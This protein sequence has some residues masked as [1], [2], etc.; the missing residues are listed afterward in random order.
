MTTPSSPPPRWRLRG[1]DGFT[2]LAAIAVASICLLLASAVVAM[3][4]G[5]NRA[6]GVDRNR[7]QA[8]AAAEGGIDTALSVL[9]QLDPGSQAGLLTSGCQQTL[10]AAPTAAGTTVTLKYAFYLTASGGSPVACPLQNGRGYKRVE[11]TSMARQLTGSVDRTATATATVVLEAP[12][13]FAHTV[14]TGG[15]ITATGLTTSGAGMY[16]AGSMTCTDSTSA[17]GGL[18]VMGSLTMANGCDVDGSLSVAGSWSCSSSTV[19]GSVL[20]AGSASLSN[21]CRVGGDLAVGGAMTISSGASVG[22]QRASGVGTASATA[23]AARR[24]MP[25]ITYD[26]SE[27]SP[28][29][30]QTLAS[31]GA[32]GCS[33][34]Y[35]THAVTAPVPVVVDA[36][37]CAPLYFDNLTLQLGTDLTVFASGFSG[38]NNLTV[39]SLDGQPHSFRLIVP[40][41]SSTGDPCATGGPST[42]INGWPTDPLISTFLYTPGTLSMYRDATVRGALYACSTNLSGKLDV[43]YTTVPLPPR[44]GG[45]LYGLASARRAAVTG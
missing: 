7:T 41:A 44:V 43:R 38:Q 37:S 3:A 4:I 27:W 35:L 26:P 20:A 28:A 40:A 22:G 39:T 8:T 33:L 15:S 16:A 19:S 5:G 18:T 36:R 45:G 21:Q 17:R 6:A 24:T 23:A 13:L 1:D 25:A 2:L 10:A 42:T 11:V 34:S 9:R 29:P 30:A 31:L 12:S 14:F 32:T